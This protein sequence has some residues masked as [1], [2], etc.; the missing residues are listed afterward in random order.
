MLS[1]LVAAVIARGRALETWETCTDDCPYADNGICDDDGPGALTAR[2]SIG[3]DCTDCGQRLLEGCAPGCYAFMMNDGICDP[4]CNTFPCA[5]N[6]CTSAQVEAQCITALSVTMAE[7]P[8]N[9]VFELSY[10]TAP[11]VDVA[12]QI[13]LEHVAVNVDPSTFESFVSVEL[14]TIFE[15]EDTRI[16]RGSSNPCCG[17]IRNML[18]LTTEEAAA[19][20]LAVLKAQ[21]ARSFWLP[22]VLAL[23]QHATPEL[24]WRDVQARED[25]AGMALGSGSEGGV[26][27]L[28][29]ATAVWVPGPPNASLGRQYM[30]LAT[31]THVH[32][33][34][35]WN[36]FYFPFDRHTIVLVLSVAGT[37]L[38]T[39][40]SP[41][42]VAQHEREIVAAASGWRSLSLASRHPSDASGQP[43]V[44]RCEVTVELERVSMSHVV[45]ELVPTSLVVFTSLLVLNLNPMDAP[46]LAGRCSLTIVAL[47]L[48]ST[49]MQQRQA[50]AWPYLTWT[51]L[52]GLLQML[53][54]VLVLGETLYVHWLHR[55]GQPEACVAVDTAARLF[56]PMAYLITLG[57]MLSLAHGA[58][59]AAA[60]IGALGALLIA[61][62]SFGY[63]R[64]QLRTRL[65]S[66]HRMLRKLAS[67]L[68]DAD[69]LRSVFDL[70]DTSRTGVLEEVE[71]K[72]VLQAMYP[73]LLE[74]V[75]GGVRRV[76][77]EGPHRG[78]VAFEDFLPALEE[79]NQ[80]LRRLL[81]H[82][83]RRA[84]ARPQCTDGAP[85]DKANK[86]VPAVAA[87]GAV[88]RLSQRRASHVSS[89]SFRHLHFTSHSTPSSAKA[90]S[91]SK[92]N[93]LA[94][95]SSALSRSV[96][97][98]LF[99][100]KKRVAPSSAG[101]DA[102]QDE[103]GCSAAEAACNNATAEARPWAIAH[104]GAARGGL[105][106]VEACVNGYSGQLSDEDEM[107]S[108]GSLRRRR[109]AVGFQGPKP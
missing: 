84:S 98:R 78:A 16:F 33:K 26:A 108:S 32:V 43:V 89:T 38:S 76:M 53:T 62:L 105:D 7:P 52:W 27:P 109:V 63:Y 104:Q 12:A 31:A 83:F 94:H 55:T 54:L 4:A 67:N 3:T 30:H 59:D 80:Y 93:S 34:Q 21:Y 66:R 1:A 96:S 48:V 19:P 15:W 13:S 45:R 14:G 61:A 18:S 47:L 70:F 60:L 39:C 29:E 97:H 99:G 71:V 65:V 100:S 11:P 23:S 95:S 73:G 82:S 101:A 46:L 75:P 36:F 20:E 56:A 92:S 86:T 5:H 40:A 74:A 10:N 25:F 2:C 107:T 85:G 22:S 24:R 57:S 37:N 81:P 77:R 41:N 6:D 102:Q 35:D 91:S 106:D 50:E 44:S 69:L 64:R 90:P 28:D 72:R 9:G 49:S 87:V 51:G 42:F 17:V 58:F 79:W 8:T 88:S 103:T 68:H